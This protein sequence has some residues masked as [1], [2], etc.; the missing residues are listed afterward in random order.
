MSILLTDRWGRAV[1]LADSVS[2]WTYTLPGCSVTLPARDDTRGL[3]AMAAHD[4]PPRQPTAE[5]VRAQLVQAV[6]DHLDAT[7]RADDWDSIYTAALRAAFPGPWQAKGIAYA[8][9]MD[10]CWQKCHEVEAAVAVGQRAVPTPEDLIAEL[11]AAPSKAN[12]ED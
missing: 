12:T 2:G 11:P 7:A 10:A 6:Q 5:E 9:W 8:Q 1:E 4:A 3:D